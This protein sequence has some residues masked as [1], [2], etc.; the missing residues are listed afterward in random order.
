MRK[1]KMKNISAGHKMVQTRDITPPPQNYLNILRLIPN[2]FSEMRIIIRFG[3]SNCNVKH[4]KKLI[5]ILLMLFF[6]DRQ[7]LLSFTLFLSDYSAQY[8]SP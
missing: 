5:A 6:R 8:D 2:S 4:S 1:P 3:V 7:T